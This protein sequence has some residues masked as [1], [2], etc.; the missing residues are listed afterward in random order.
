M[1]LSPWG[2]ATFMASGVTFGMVSGRMI[3]RRSVNLLD[4]EV[5]LT[6]GA[7]WLAGIHVQHHRS[8]GTVLVLEVGLLIRL[9]H[10]EALTRER[11][12]D[13]FAAAAPDQG[14]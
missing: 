2:Y 10:D 3:A 5:L 8:P 4:M 1:N 12:L 7:T 14:P 13:R 6:G 11:H 9:E